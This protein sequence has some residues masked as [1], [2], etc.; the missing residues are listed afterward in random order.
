MTEVLASRPD[1]PQRAMLEEIRT[2]AADLV[3]SLQQNE[4]EL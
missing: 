4:E 3:R 2:L 1:W